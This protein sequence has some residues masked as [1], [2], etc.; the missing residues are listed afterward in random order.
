MDGA[1]AFPCVEQVVAAA[2]IGRP[3]R[4]HKTNASAGGTLLIG[5]PPVL[6][7]EIIRVRVAHR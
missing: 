3:T 7:L 4:L 2:T 1:K 6:F 5:L